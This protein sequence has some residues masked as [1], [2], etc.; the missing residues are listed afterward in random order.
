MGGF[1]VCLGSKAQTCGESESEKP[2]QINELQGFWVC[3]GVDV[4]ITGY[5]YMSTIVQVEYFLPYK[6]TTY[7]I[8]D[9]R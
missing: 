5:L 2:L 6:S 7:L 9:P 1:L 8:Y 4:F 3:G